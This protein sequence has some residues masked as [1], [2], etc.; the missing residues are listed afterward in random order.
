MQGH[1]VAFCGTFGAIFAVITE[2]ETLVQAHK[3]DVEGHVNGL[4]LC[5]H[6]GRM[7]LA[8]CGG[9]EKIFDRFNIV[10]VKPWIALWDIGAATGFQLRKKGRFDN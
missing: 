3:I 9:R 1:N 7:L 2:G 4:D 5:I 6:E 8:A 10:S